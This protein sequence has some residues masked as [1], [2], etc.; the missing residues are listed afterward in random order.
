M[1]FVSSAK[2]KNVVKIDNNKLA[3]KGLKI[4]V[5]TLINVLGAFDRPKA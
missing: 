5:I 2:D 4:W 1:Y 3:Y